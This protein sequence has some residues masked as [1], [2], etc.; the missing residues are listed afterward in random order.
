MGLK[1]DDIMMG[2]D[3]RFRQSGGS[4]GIGQGGDIFA[5][6]NRDLRGPGGIF[7]DQGLEL[8][9]ACLLHILRGG[10]VHFPVDLS[11]GTFGQ[12]LF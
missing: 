6:L 3:G 8:M 5:G 1:G 11:Q 2:Q 7:F 9:E 4:P 12:M 10:R